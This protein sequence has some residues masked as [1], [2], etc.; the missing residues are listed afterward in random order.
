MQSRAERYF[1]CSPNLCPGIVTGP[2]ATILF[3]YLVKATGNQGSV[4]GLEIHIGPR[5]S[6]LVPSK[7][8]VE[9]PY[10]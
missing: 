10:R 7:Y 2:V 1:V 9:V 6:S 4:M 8:I 3:V 5:K